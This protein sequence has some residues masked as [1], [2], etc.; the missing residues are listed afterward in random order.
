MFSIVFAIIAVLVAFNTVRIAIYSSS[1]EISTM[2]LV[3]ASN[4]FIRGP[5]LVQGL[6]SG[7]LAAVITLLITFFV[8]YGLN[9]KVKVIAPEIGLLSLFFGNIGIL[10]LIQL[11]SGIVL[12]AISSFIATRKYLKI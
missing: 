10:F 1:E 4:W 11:V 7:I 3:G 2:R 9:A 6:I 12:G 8:C 5:F